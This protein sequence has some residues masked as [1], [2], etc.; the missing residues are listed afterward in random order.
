MRGHA[1]AGP[2]CARDGDF[3]LLFAAL[4]PLLLQANTAA[5]I[6]DTPLEAGK[7]ILR[8][9]I[10]RETGFGGVS[11]SLLSNDGDYRLV[12]R[13]DF[14]YQS[15]ISIQFLR[16]NR[17]EQPTALPASLTRLDIDEGVS[18]VWE[19]TYAGIFSWDGE[20]DT[21]A[22]SAAAMLQDYTGG[23]RMD[24]RDRSGRKVRALFDAA[25]GQSAIRRATSACY[26]L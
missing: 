15:D 16:A 5:P 8:E 17:Q 6:T 18:L 26:N 9:T 14:S 2:S 4:M 22:T 12:V 3:R 23:L 10:E 24:A 25:A 11:A 21:E 7:W 20:E 1:Y 19:Q 13:C